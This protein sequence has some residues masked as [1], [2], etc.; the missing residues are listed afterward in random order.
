VELGAS[1]LQVATFLGNTVAVA[2][3][4]YFKTNKLSA[5]AADIY[6]QKKMEQA[7]AAEGGKELTEQRKLQGELAALGLSDGGTE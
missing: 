7:R 6:R 2:E 5:Q 4:H 3:R 1:P